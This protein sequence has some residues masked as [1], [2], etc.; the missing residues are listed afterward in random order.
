M[1]TVLTSDHYTR[2]LVIV[3]IFEQLVPDL[4]VL[5]A[6]DNNL[7]TTFEDFMKLYKKDDLR[8]IEPKVDIYYNMDPE[9]LGSKIS[10]VE[11]KFRSLL[12]S[13]FLEL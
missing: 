10:V 6:K 1:F 4:I 5:K 13:F 12:T 8:I 3:S 7:T 11:K 9:T 2:Y